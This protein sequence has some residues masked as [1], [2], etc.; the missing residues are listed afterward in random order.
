MMDMKDISV[1]GFKAGAVKAGIRGKD[2]LDVGL[3]VSE[4][5][6]TAAGVFTTSKVKAAPVLLDIEHLQGEKSQAIIVNSGIANACT[7]EAG[8]NLARMT[9]NLVAQKLA[10]DSRLV[11]VCSTGVI[12][13]QLGIEIFDNSID[14]LIA[15]LKTDGLSNVPLAM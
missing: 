2:R 9:A 10:I 11:Q 3:I 13:M 1:P 4:V 6:S 12:G 5:P 7:G 15:S 8:M 14:S